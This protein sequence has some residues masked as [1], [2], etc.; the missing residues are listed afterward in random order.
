MERAGHEHNR[1]PN[2]SK[3]LPRHVKVESVSAYRRVP[4]ASGCGPRTTNHCGWPKSRRPRQP[5]KTDG[6]REENLV[7]PKLQVHPDEGWGRRTGSTPARAGFW[8]DDQGDRWALLLLTRDTTGSQRG[9]RW[10]PN[11]TGGLISV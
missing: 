9:A 8:K 7:Q 1:Y 11:S 10:N 3:E 4:T 2:N 6:V 5:G